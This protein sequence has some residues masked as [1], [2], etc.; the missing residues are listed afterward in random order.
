MPRFVTPTQSCLHGETAAHWPIA[1]L[2]TGDDSG[3]GFR[4]VFDASGRKLGNII[5]MLPFQSTSSGLV[6]ISTTPIVGLKSGTMEVTVGVATSIAVTTECR[7]TATAAPQSAACHR[8]TGTFLPPSTFV[9]GVG[10]TTPFFAAWFG[11]TDCSGPPYLESGQYAGR[12]LSPPP[13]ASPTFIPNGPGSVA[14]T[15]LRDANGVFVVDA[16]GFSVVASKGILVPGRLAYVPDLTVDPELWTLPLP[17]ES[18]P[19]GASGKFLG[20][21]LQTDGI[22]R[23]VGTLST[24]NVNRRLVPAITIDLSPFL[25]SPF[26][27]R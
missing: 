13:V 8:F 19:V 23:T 22:C 14:A 2:A 9:S 25:V 27:F 12:Q 6:G 15:F 10:T 17:P 11:S 7:S 5:G 3:V 18:L 24:D 21:Y 26:T 4:A 16:N 20:S 1:P